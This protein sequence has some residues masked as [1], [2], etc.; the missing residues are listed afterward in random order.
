MDQQ[1]RTCGWP[2]GGSNRA[3]R[4]LTAPI[5]PPQGTAQRSAT[6]SPYGREEAVI[7]ETRAARR[8]AGGYIAVVTVTVVFV[9]CTLV[10]FEGDGAA[11]M[12]GVWLIVGMMPWSLLLAA[13]NQ[14]DRQLPPLLSSSVCLVLLR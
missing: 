3:S 5:T 4:P 9:I 11:N 13:W 7:P 6:T 2:V 12:S 8:F 10:F 1:A 14:P